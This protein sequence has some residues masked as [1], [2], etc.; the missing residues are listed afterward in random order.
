ML[1]GLLIF[2]AS[3]ICLAMPAAAES[4]I[5]G[6][7][8]GGT[9]VDRKSDM[10][11]GDIT[12]GTRYK[13]TPFPRSASTATSTR[14]ATSTRTYTQPSTSTRTYSTHAPRSTYSTGTVTYSAPS[15]T[16]YTTGSRYVTSHPTNTHYP[17]T[18]H[19]SSGSRYVTTTPQ[20]RYHSGSSYYY[21]QGSHHSGRTTMY[22]SGTSGYVTTQPATTY[23]GTRTYTTRPTTHHG[24]TRTYTTT[25]RTHGT[26]TTHPHN[27][28][29]TPRVTGN[30]ANSFTT[31][32]PSEP[33]DEFSFGKPETYIRKHPK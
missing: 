33:G 12:G 22:S 6:D 24:T 31:V 14:S 28:Y 3:A 5:Q 13:C 7:R 16:T 15:H 21:P 29:G 23:H 18:S 19:Y 8:C 25:P 27:P 32:S 1:K 4:Y 10:M 9:Y 20:T 26:V 11:A 30:L 17:S 2:G